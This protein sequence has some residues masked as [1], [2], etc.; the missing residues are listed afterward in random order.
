MKLKKFIQELKK[1]EEEQGGDVMVV[2]ADYIAV[3]KPV[4]DQHCGRKVVITDHPSG[5]KNLS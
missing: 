5:F 2:V 3:V 4:F 1:I